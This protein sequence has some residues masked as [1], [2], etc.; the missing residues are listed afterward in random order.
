MRVFYINLD[1]RTDRRAYMEAQ[2]EALGLPAER[3]PATTPADISAADLAPATYGDARRCLTPTE[4]ATSISHQRVWRRMIEDGN[5]H[6][7]VLEDDCELSPR[8]PAFLAEIDRAGSVPGLVRL[9][10]RLRSQILSRRA[11]RSVL[12]IGLHRPFT[13]EWG[14]AAYIIS[15]EEALRVLASPE[16][17]RVPI[18]DMLLSPDSA[19]RVSG[20]LLQAVPALAF[21]PED[22]VDEGTQPASVRRSDVQAERLLR[23]EDE[24]P[25]AKVRKLAREVRRIRRQVADIRRVLRHR[26][27]G[28]TMV[29]PFARDPAT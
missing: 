26:I 12:D 11:T 3:F 6:A 17:F 22:G 16:R 25:K 10:T 28:R 8:F 14:S 24:K 18:D 4:I 9:E 20:S 5:P 13:W 29:V 19:M 15:A 2:F 27:F 23:F 21:V 1:R 7:L